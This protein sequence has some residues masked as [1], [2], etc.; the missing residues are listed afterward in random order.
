MSNTDDKQFEA[1]QK[2]LDDARKKGDLPRSADL[3]TAAA[4]GGI[5]LVAISGG[6]FV[7]MQMSEILVQILVRAPEIQTSTIS[8][9]N[10]G[11]I[12]GFVLSGLLWAI[13]WFLVPAL[14][15][16]LS[17]IAQKSLVFSPQRIKP[18]LSRISITE[19]AKKRLG[20]SGLFEFFKSCLKL[21]VFSATAAYFISHLLPDLTVLPLLEPRKIVLRIFNSLQSLINFVFLISLAVGF[22]DLVWQREE[23]RRRNRMSRQ[24]MTD[25]TKESDGDPNVKQTRRQRGQEIA[26]NQMLADIPGSDVV[27]VNPTHYAVV[28]KWDRTEGSAPECVAKGV[29]EIAR[30][31]RETAA[32]SGVPIFRD[33]TTARALF[34]TIEI[35]QQILPDH[36]KA[37]A[38]AIRYAETVGRRG[39]GGLT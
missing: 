24:E 8:R 19:N 3:N 37:V 12:M 31:I 11:Y 32:Q 4:Y 6:G 28:L 7:L 1:S 29:D 33:P 13:P 38:A 30:R 9:A 27:I 16:I 15:V 2:K 25:E 14:L 20:K 35:G 10:S 18:K 17:V 39:A 26:L 36:F 23:H 5:I 21:L 34:A 22:V